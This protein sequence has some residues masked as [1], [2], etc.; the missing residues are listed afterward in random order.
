MQF[1]NDLR[2]FKD[3]LNKLDNPIKFSWS[4]N[5]VNGNIS[6]EYSDNQETS[7]EDENIELNWI[8][9]SFPD[10]LIIIN[11]KHLIFLEVKAQGEDDYNSEKTKSLIKAYKKYVEVYKNQLKNNDLKN[12]KFASFT[13]A[14]VF[15]PK[16][17]SN[18]KPTIIGASTNEEINKRL[19]HQIENKDFHSIE[20]LFFEISKIK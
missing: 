9:R 4:S 1:I 11:E 15:Y 13:M 5:V 2:K 8:K 18:T 3:N 20:T 12:N 16:M 17:F 10:F 7:F 19:N 6:F 14:V